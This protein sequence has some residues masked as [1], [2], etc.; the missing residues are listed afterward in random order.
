MEKQFL[1]G[2]DQT[3][4]IRLGRGQYQ[5]REQSL[6]VWNGEVLEKG[7]QALGTSWH[8]GLMWHQVV[9]SALLCLL[10]CISFIIEAK[11][12]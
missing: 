7:S 5:L 8:G 12:P 6:G 2:S 4:Q 9:G 10:W 1:H 11:I 3:D